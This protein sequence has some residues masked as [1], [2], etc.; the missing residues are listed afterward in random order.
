MI[1]DIIKER[2]NYI[3]INKRIEFLV[4]IV[5]GLVVRYIF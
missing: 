5:I 1:R 2:I 4:L 3:Y